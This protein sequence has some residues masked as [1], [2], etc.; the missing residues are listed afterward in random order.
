MSDVGN[1]QVILMTACVWYRG[2][3]ML[4]QLVW[5]GMAWCGEVDFQWWWYSK[6]VVSINDQVVTAGVITSLLTE[7]TNL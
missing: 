5:L 7:Y 2:G 3:S 1:I 4:A 6:A